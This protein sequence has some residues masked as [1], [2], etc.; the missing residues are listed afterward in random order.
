MKENTDF[1]N[2]GKNTPYKAPTGFFDTISERTLQKAKQREQNQ[3]KTRRLWRVVSLAASLAALFFLGYFKLE[4]NTRPESQQ[5]IQEII[6]SETQSVQQG[7]VMS[8]KPT[9]SE[10][11]KV[12]F[13]KEAISDVLTDMTDEELS[14]MAAMFQTDPFTSESGQ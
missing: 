13:E 2:I 5:M 6:P 8:A 3:Q 10:T 7:P 9:G 12:T 1:Q 4:L 11:M 14:Q